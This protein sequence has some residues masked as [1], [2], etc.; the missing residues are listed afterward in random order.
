LSLKSRQNPAL[1]L[2]RYQARS[3][4]LAQRHRATYCRKTKETA[5]IHLPCGILATLASAV[6]KQLE[7]GAAT[8][9]ALAPSTTVLDSGQARPRA[10]LLE[11]TGLAS[12]SFLSLHLTN[13]LQRLRSSHC[14]TLHTYR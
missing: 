1:E 14:P 10:S 5:S 7:R 9:T 8:L 2:R 13:R 4:G 6:L 12:W 11:R 3:L